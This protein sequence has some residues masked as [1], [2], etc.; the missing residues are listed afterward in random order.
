VTNASDYV[1][2]L[3]LLTEARKKLISYIDLKHL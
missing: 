3:A 1:N 2:I